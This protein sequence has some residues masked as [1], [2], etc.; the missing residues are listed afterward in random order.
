MPFDILIPSVWRALL[1]R[2]RSRFPGRTCK[3]ARVPSRSCF[4]SLGNSRSL[5]KNE[6][7]AIGGEGLASTDVGASFPRRGAFPPAIR[8]R[9]PEVDARSSS[10]E[11]WLGNPRRSPCRSAAARR[12]SPPPAALSCRSP[13]S[14]REWLTGASLRG[15]AA[16]MGRDGPTSSAISSRRLMAARTVP[17]TARARA[18]TSPS[19]PRAAGARLCRPERPYGPGP[20]SRASSRAAGRKC[21]P[22]FSG[23]HRRARRRAARP[24]ARRRSQPPQPPPAAQS[25]GGLHRE[26][27]PKVIGVALV[28]QRPSCKRFSSREA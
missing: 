28:A 18:R 11:D 3:R 9:V 7:L 14:H 13:R 5:L 27:E 25:L 10:G 26:F 6:Q 22:R 1:P 21:P 16:S 12:G 20:A 23:R 15:C 17:L 2:A 19:R 4:S 24:T 8:G